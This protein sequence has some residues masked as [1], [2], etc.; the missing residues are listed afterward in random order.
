MADP[1]D[2]AGDPIIDESVTFPA[3]QTS[4][5]DHLV[6]RTVYGDKAFAGNFL[7]VRRDTVK[8]PN[9]AHATREFIVHPGASMVVALLDDGRVVME[10]QYRHPLKRVMIEMPA[11][12][13]DAH[14]H[15]FRTAMREL[16][17]ETGYSA[18]EWARAGILHN[19]IAY[20]D[21]GI[22]V[23]FARGLTLGASHLDE[24]E[25][26]DVMS[27]S[28]AEI[29]AGVRDG[30][31]TDAKTMIGLLYLQKLRAGLWPLEWHSTEAL[32]ALT[33]PS[34]AVAEGAP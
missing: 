30:R 29:D 7:H 8:L 23:W 2:L 3:S 13:I 22:E 19:A 15:P 26:L 14:E 20:S 9:G 16:R 18:R 4:L 32:M 24:G 34:L 12:K 1:T 5:D 17:E 28:E 11:G 21:E 25:T 10:R 33:E 31:I 27:L 6:E